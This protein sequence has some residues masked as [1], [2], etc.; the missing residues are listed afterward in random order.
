MGLRCLLGHDFGEPETEREREEAGNEVVVTVRD[1]KR[2][3]R[4]EETQVVSENK[5]V[6]SIER[7]RRDEPGGHAE[8]RDRPNATGDA[9]SAEASVDTA[10][11]GGPDHEDG[12]DDIIGT[13][14][15]ES[16][17]STATPHPSVDDPQSD[18]LDGVEDDAVIMDEGSTDDATSED[19]E[20]DAKPAVGVEFGDESEFDDVDDDEDAVILGDDAEP[21]GDE[22]LDD[23]SVANVESAAAEEET[24]EGD[25]VEGDADDTVE[26]PTGD[27]WPDHD[28]VNE[29]LTPDH[30]GVDEGLTPD[31]NATVVAGEDPNPRRNGTD[32]DDGPTFDG[33]GE[34]V[35][36]SS[37]GRTT[38]DL[39][40][41]SGEADLEYRCPECGMTQPVGNSSM[42]AGDICPECRRGYVEEHERD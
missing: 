34:V 9:W 32:E 38:V 4:C 5:E 17:E 8:P 39:G 14:E 40:R 31:D 24:H 36:Q 15:A 25:G 28:G 18:D 42:R 6:K 26:D 3:Q 41:S 20:V 7:L 11:G 19:D 12:V 37:G 21:A 35:G 30:D 33:A 23:P 16:A 13:A 2:C 29:G 22:E 27:E 1:V 10:A